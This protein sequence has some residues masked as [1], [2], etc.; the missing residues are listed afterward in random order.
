[1]ALKVVLNDDKEQILRATE[2]FSIVFQLQNLLTY[3]I[4]KKRVE[5]GALTLR[6]WYYHIDS[7][8]IEYYNQEDQHFYPLV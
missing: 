2:K 4:V 7:G 8:E 3:P 1:L 5:E 6:G